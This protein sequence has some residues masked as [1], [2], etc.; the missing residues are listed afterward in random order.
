[1][2]IRAEQFTAPIAYHGEGAVWSSVWG[3]LRCVDML[4]G[5]VLHIDTDGTVTRHHLGTVAA[6]IRPCL[7]GLSV[8]ALERTVAF[9]NETSGSI[10]PLTAPF[11][12]L[13]ARLNEGTCSPDGSLLIGSLAYDH[14]PDGGALYRLAATD[15]APS[16]LA[17]STISNGI[18]YSPDGSIVY[19]VDSAQHTVGR[20]SVD[21]NGNWIEHAV[22]ARID[23]SDGSPD[24]LWV[25]VDGGV[26]VALF[27]G[28]SVR[29]YRPTG[30]LDEIVSVG[31]RQVTSCTFGGPTGSTLFI[32]TS[33]E[34]LAPEDDPRAGSIF[35]AET[36]VRG[37]DAF[38][39]GQTPL[40]E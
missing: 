13:G 19:Y 32:T 12:P 10:T 1:M 3:G 36:G 8:V 14:A 2:A 25:D 16:M 29:R 4:A 37:L 30:E 6:M 28:S 15:S 34:N 9:W 22:L 24:G 11:V 18:G 7:P 20:F 26:W 21:E 23:A 39:F 35:R 17:K 33:R 27:G 38:A 31:A 40:P 5:D